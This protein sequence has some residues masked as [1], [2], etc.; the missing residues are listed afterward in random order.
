MSCEENGN[1]CGT[2]FSSLSFLFP[3]IAPIPST[4]L[5]ML[6]GHDCPANL[7][8]DCTQLDFGRSAGGKPS[9]TEWDMQP[10]FDEILATAMVEIIGVE[11]SLKVLDRAAD[12]YRE[13]HPNSPLNAD[14]VST[15]GYLKMFFDDEDEHGIG[16]LADVTGTSAR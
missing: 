16:A 14:Y 15:E 6:Q 10:Q 13:R 5:S 9:E 8:D 2:G 1:G 3:I 7:L 4:V 11:K 12:L